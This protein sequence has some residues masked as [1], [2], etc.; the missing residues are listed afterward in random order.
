V[1][2]VVPGAAIVRCLEELMQ[3]PGWDAVGREHHTD[4]TFGLTH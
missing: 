4:S 1:V 3:D 2:D